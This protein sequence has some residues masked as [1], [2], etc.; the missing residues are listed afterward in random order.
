MCSF[1]CYLYNKR[2]NNHPFSRND[3]QMLRRKKAP[4]QMPGSK[5]RSQYCQKVQAYP[6]IK[7]VHE[8]ILS[9]YSLDR[10]LSQLPAAVQRLPEHDSL[11]LFS[12]QPCRR[13]MRTW[14]SVLGWGVLPRCTPKASMSSCRSR[15]ASQLFLL[16]VENMAIFKHHT[17]DFQKNHLCGPHTQN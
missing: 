7:A 5:W 3:P 17:L 10:G 13:S 16:R 9:S 4:L 14:T 2:E 6:I 12:L 1:F 15:Q 11:S 8:F